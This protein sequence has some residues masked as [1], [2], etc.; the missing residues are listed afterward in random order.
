MMKDPDADEEGR[1]D[2][3]QGRKEKSQER[4]LGR[5]AIQTA[6]NFRPLSGKGK[7]SRKHIETLQP[8]EKLAEGVE[9]KG[10]RK[11]RKVIRRW[12]ERCCLS[13]MESKSARNRRRKE[14][15]L[16]RA[17]EKANGSG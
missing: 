9:G 13:R 6:V 14:F 17:E 2:D 5:W 7:K 11:M 4:R 16:V 1:R 12:D 15:Q 3:A 10:R 8:R